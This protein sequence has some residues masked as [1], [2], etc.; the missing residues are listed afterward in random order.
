[1]ITA[2][3]SCAHPMAP[4]SASERYRRPLVL[5]PASVSL[6][7]SHI[8]LFLLQS[9]LGDGKGPSVKVGKPRPEREADLLGVTQGS[10]ERR[11]VVGAELCQH[12][13]PSLTLSLSA[14]DLE[15]VTFLSVF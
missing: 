1:M 6:P 4:S 14:N 2:Q 11:A 13:G 10:T 5:P 9:R 7:I 3:S 8:R 15:K 12:K